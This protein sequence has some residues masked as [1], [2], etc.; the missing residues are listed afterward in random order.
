MGSGVAVGEA[1]ELRRIGRYEIVREVGRGAS[2]IVYL[3]RQTDLDRNVALKELAHFHAADPAF[4]ERFLRESRLAGSLNHPNI[5][6]VHEYFEHEG[7]PYIAMEYLER[8]SLRPLTGALTTA[9]VVGVLE[10]LLAGLAHAESSGIVHRDLKPENVLVTSNGGVKIADFGIAKALEP[11]PGA[12]LTLSDATVG[13][14]AYM[15]PEQAT[16][17]AVGTWTDLYAAG[18]VAF[19]LLSGEV[20]YHESP[21]AM[22]VLLQHV[23]DPVPSLRAA[24]PD[25]D[26][27]LARWVERMLAKAPRDRPRSAAAAWEELEEIAIRAL[28]ARWRRES[29]IADTPPVAR[30]RDTAV[31]APVEAEPPK[32][33]K[34]KVW[35]A[36]LA[37]TFALA[38][39]GVAAAV[40]WPEGGEP[41]ATTTFET[42]GQRGSPAASP[43]PKPKTVAAAVLRDFTV[44]EHATTVQATLLLRGA[45]LRP[46]ALVVQ[47]ADLTDGRAWFELRQKGIDKRTARAESGDVE[48]LVRK[49]DGFLRIDVETVPGDFEQ[50]FVIRLDGR[51]V[52]VTLTKP[53]VIPPVVT[54]PTTETET[55]EETPP[56]EEPTEEPPPE[57][58]PPINI[59]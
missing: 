59:G 3:A 38:G 32:S 58:D 42:Q 33:S 21:V 52:L 15:A 54:T 29:R 8:G 36:A 46:D 14:P 56:G 5:V 17:G 1:S 20:P 48:V 47:D 39:A 11:E 10:G 7:T 4:V 44:V 25:L 24:R 18:V 35:I 30:I 9:Q 45:A 53:P 26:P 19:E 34:R 49:G 41:P 2:A 37:T 16:S 23:N 51:T 50:M 13:T 12:P 27:A 57:T 31:T 55:P 22:A 40:A 28:G 6:T 43:T